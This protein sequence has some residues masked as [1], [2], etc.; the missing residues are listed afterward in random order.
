MPSPGRIRIHLVIDASVNALID[1]IAAK[2][3]RSRSA[4]I[5]IAMLE[6][7]KRYYSNTKSGAKPSRSDT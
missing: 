1:K 2:E 5:E 6:Y 4:V 3:R 7:E